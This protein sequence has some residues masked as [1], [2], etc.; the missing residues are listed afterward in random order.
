MV[1]RARRAPGRG[2]RA[3]RHRRGPRRSRRPGPRASRNRLQTATLLRRHRGAPLRRRVRRRPARRGEGPGQGAGVQLPRRVRPVGPEEPA[4]RAV[5][6]LQRPPPARASTSGCSRCP[7]G[8][9]ST[10]GSTSPRSGIEL[11]SIY[12]AHHREV[13]RRD[14]ML[15]GRLAPSSRACPAR[16]SR[17][18]RCASAPSATSPAPVRSSRRPRRSTRSSPRWPPPASP[19]GAPPGPT[20][21]SARPAWKTARRRAT[22][23][24]RDAPPR[25][26]RVGRRRQVD[27][28]RAPALRLEGDLRGPARG[29]GAHVAASGAT[30][31]PTWRCSPTACGPSGSRASRSTWPTATSPRR[32]GSSS[33]PTPPA[34]SSTRATWSP[35]R[36]PPTWR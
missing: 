19:S 9:S 2:L 13:F 18:A 30:S 5:E 10:S 29:G 36:R 24:G 35:G 12:F 27:A 6:P 34:T 14:G 4:P 3:G 23:D 26:G 32:S 28:H 7:T 31:T 17:S 22:S 25:H 16:R 11:P 21:A 1:E 20:T 8:P 15:A 33:S